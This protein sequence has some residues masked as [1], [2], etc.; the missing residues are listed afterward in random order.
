[1]VK[2]DALQ[3]RTVPS[4]E[5]QLIKNFTKRNESKSFCCFR[6]LKDNVWKM[7]IPNAPATAIV[8]RI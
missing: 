3:N 1:M 7:A 2:N 5:Q 6:R 4:V 8:K